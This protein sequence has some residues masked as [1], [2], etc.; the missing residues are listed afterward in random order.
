VRPR[1]DLC[2]KYYVCLGVSRLIKSLLENVTSCGFPC[3]DIL[4]G[5]MCLVAKKAVARPGC[6]AGGSHCDRGLE[7]GSRIP[8]NSL[9]LGA[10]T[11]YHLGERYAVLQ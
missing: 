1:V 4:C 8:A 11:H 10:T 7:T 3:I 5:Q 9:D 6:C 2:T